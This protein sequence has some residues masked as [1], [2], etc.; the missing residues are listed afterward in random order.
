[1]VPVQSRKRAQR[2]DSALIDPESVRIQSVIKYDFAAHFGVPLGSLAARAIEIDRALLSW[3]ARHPEGIIVSLG[4]GLETQSRRVDNG[5]MRW[6]TVDLPD[7]TRL[8][9]RFLVQTPVFVTSQ[10]VR[11][12]LFGWTR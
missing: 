9:E 6:L 7:A 2:P 12:T 8:R 5:R 1:M 10:R 11:S 3:L 4:E